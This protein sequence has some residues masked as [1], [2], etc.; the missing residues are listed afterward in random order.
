MRVEF[1][2]SFAVPLGEWPDVNIS[3]AI[4]I[5]RLWIIHYPGVFTLVGLFL[6]ICVLLMQT[7][8]D[9]IGDMWESF[10]KVCSESFSYL[11]KY[12]E[13]VGI[14][15]IKLDTVCADLRAGKKQDSFC[16]N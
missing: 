8:L 15:S 4:D 12:Y 13:T 5:T 9:W 2:G 14:Q 6:P 16:T 1:L 7:N 3:R 10:K 11:Q